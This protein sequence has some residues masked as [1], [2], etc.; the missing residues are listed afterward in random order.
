[1]LDFLVQIMWDLANK[2]EVRG[3]KKP[4][5]R[6]ILAIGKKKKKNR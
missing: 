2:A 4:E 6:D 1:M 3:V 5:E